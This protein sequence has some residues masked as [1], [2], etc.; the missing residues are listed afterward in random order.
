MY[1]P[2]INILNDMEEIISFIDRFSFGILLSKNDGRIIGTHIPIIS[3]LNSQ[4]LKLYTHLAL[5]NNQWKEIEKQ[6][7][8]LIFSEPHAYI[9]TNN[10]IAMEAV[11]TW[12]YMAVHIYGNVSI[13]HNK[14]DI[15]GVMDQTI[16]KYERDYLG[17]WNNLSEEFKNKMLK[18]IVTLRIDVTNIEA[19]AK[20]SQNKSEHE[21]ENITGSLLNSSLP[22]DKLMAEYMLRFNKK[23][24]LF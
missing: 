24:N 10:Y 16:I 18:G 22:S 21:K 23:N 17:K 20:L 11:P 7:V 6:E 12:N 13:L 3:N 5:A 14:D 19:K 15:Q 4:N 8:L 2:K 9:S 1:I